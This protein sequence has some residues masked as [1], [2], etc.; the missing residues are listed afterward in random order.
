MKKVDELM[1]LILGFLGKY[2]VDFNL[3]ENTLMSQVPLC[4]GGGIKSIDDAEKLLSMGFEKIALSSHF[5]EDPKSISIFSKK[6]GSQSIVIVLDIKK[7]NNDYEIFTHN[8]LRRSNHSLKEILD[9]INSSNNVG[10][11][12]INSIAS[13]LT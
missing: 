8:G 10:E 1:I 3:L 11:V 12:V 6:L 7:V 5:L 4:Y 9:F 13:L 2:R